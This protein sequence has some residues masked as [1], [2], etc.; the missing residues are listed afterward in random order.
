MH[1]SAAQ[2][3]AMLLLHSCLLDEAQTPL[4]SVCC[5]LVVQQAVQQQ[6]RTQGGSGGYE[7]P[8]NSQKIAKNTPKRAKLWP[9]GAFTA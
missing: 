8:Q 6:A 5:G 9:T 7:D 3:R 1:G 4:A 2:L